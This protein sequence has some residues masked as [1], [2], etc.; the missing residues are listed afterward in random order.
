MLAGLLWDILR[1]VYDCWLL[2]DGAALTSLVC[3]DF[4]DDDILGSFSDSKDASNNSRKA[5]EVEQKVL[6]PE[7]IEREQN[8]HIKDVATILGLPPESVA[9]LLRYGRWNKEKLIE[10]YMDDSDKVL[11]EAGLG[12]AS[13]RTP[14]TE[15]VPGFMCD[16]CCEEGD[17]LQTYAMR[18]GHRFCVDCY[19]HYLEHKI[20]Q[21]GEAARIQ[22][23]QDKCH[24]ILDSKSLDLLVTDD[25]KGRY[26][27]SRHF[28][29]KRG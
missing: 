20:K 17:D 22:C 16:I 5:Y 1:H 7:D 3:T 18:C 15:V 27:Y 19:R 29:W 9:I 13:S 2:L 8:V 26:V 4:D 23:P 14:K 21:E 24:L 28:P 11:E 6:S 10:S 25:L 12:P